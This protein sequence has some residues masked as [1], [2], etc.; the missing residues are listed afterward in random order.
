[1]KWLRSPSSLPGV[2]LT[3]G[4]LTCYVMLACGKNDASPTPSTSTSGAPPAV[5][6][7]T[8][9]A[10]APK[11]QGKA[12]KEKASLAQLPGIEELYDSARAA[13]VG[14]DLPS[15]IKVKPK[16][17]SKMPKGERAMEV[18]AFL[19]SLAILSLDSKDVP[20]PIIEGAE[21]AIKSLDP[22]DLVLKQVSNLSQE[23]KGGKL[24]GAE[25]RREIDKLM[26]RGIPLLDTSPPHATQARLV[27]LGAYLRGMSLIAASLG[28]SKDEDKLR[29][30]AQKDDHE[31]HTKTL[32]ELPA[33][34][35]GEAAL[36]KAADALEKIAPAVN[37][38]APT[39][40][41]AKLI[42]KTL[43]DYA[44]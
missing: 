38:D 33:E 18:G 20:L 13:G 32:A 12:G 44:R 8:A 27:R 24:K 17:F 7:P 15:K 10:S 34:L 11:L 9:T 4:L 22:P 42:T 28:D 40:D 30:L 23:V 3:L 35:K 29:A 36:K 21:Q 31:F 43:A 19:A 39:P 37:R 2:P 5:S 26:A 1:M 41:D 6:T 25:L 16:D 14:T